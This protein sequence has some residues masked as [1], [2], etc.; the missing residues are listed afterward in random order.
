M[1]KRNAQP[2]FPPA[3]PAP[4]PVAPVAYTF[5]T[6]VPVLPPPE[7]P[8]DF[9]NA[10]LT[11]LVQMTQG[12]KGGDYI[13]PD[14]FRGIL[15][16]LPGTLMETAQD[17]NEKGEIFVIA[18]DV[19]FAHVKSL[20]APTSAPTVPSAHRGTTRAPRTTLP[21][22]AKGNLFMPEVPIPLP[23]GAVRGALGRKG[24]YTALFDQL[25]LNGCF[26]VPALELKDLKRLKEQ[27]SNATSNQNGKRKDKD[28]AKFVTRVLVEYDARPYG[29]TEK[30][31]TGVGVW[32]VK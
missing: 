25:K 21:P 15:A 19:A 26:L 14:I 29:Y 13:P 20:G 10:G 24:E 27:L 28:G 17:A 5:P 1:A 3:T 4:A 16:K 22:V 11:H 6:P 12:P 18:T 7:L 32:R 8:V 9:V 31:F 2:T 30:P 23:G